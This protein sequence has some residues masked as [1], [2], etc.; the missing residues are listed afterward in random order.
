M[1]L[2]PINIWVS[3]K[4]TL[5]Q[6][7]RSE[8]IT[9]SKIKVIVIRRAVGIIGT[10]HTGMYKQISMRKIVKH[11]VRLNGNILKVWICFYCNFVHTWLCA[12]PI[13]FVFMNEVIKTGFCLTAMGYLL[14]IYLNYTI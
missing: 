7:Y 3:K 10:I 4:I 8:A 13:D 5:P 12:D 9:D 1:Y 11:F 2:L 6:Q 14:A